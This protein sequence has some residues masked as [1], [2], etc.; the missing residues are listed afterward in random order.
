VTWLAQRLQ[1]PSDEVS[2]VALMRRD[3]IDH[4]RPCALVCV[5]INA[6]IGR[7]SALEA[8]RTGRDGRKD[9]NDPELPI[10]GE[11]CCGAQRTAMMW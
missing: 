3:V 5:L 4:V 6:G 2:P 10:D 11:L 7:K 8:N 1:I 9:G